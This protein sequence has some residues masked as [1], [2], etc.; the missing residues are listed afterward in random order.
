MNIKVNGKGFEAEN[1]ATLETVVSKIGM[2]GPVAVSLNDEVVPYKKL[3][4]HK[5]VEGDV[6][7]IFTMLGGG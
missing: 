4:E 6:I 7:E 3:G 1:G 5:V 2:Q